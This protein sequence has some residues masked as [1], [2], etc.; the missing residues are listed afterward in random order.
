[1]PN[2]LGETIAADERLIW[3][4]IFRDIKANGR[5][6]APRNKQVLE[7]E[8]YHYELPPYVRFCSLT[9]RA[10]KLD[11]I[12][13]E[14]LWFL[15]GDP[16]D[17]SILQYSN[18]WKNIVVRGR[19]NSNYG[20][21]FFRRGGIDWVVLELCKDKDSRR[22]CITILGSED[23]H[24]RPD[25]K[26]VP[27][28]VYLNFRIRTAPGGCD[29]LNMSVHMRSQDAVYGMGND[30]PAFSILQEI[31][32]QKLRFHKYPNLQLG[33]YHHT[34]DSFH[35]YERHYAMLEELVAEDVGFD[36]IQ[37]GVGVPYI[38]S[39]DEVDYMLTDMHNG[40]EP[41][42]EYPFAK[43]LLEVRC[44]KT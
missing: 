22:A 13:Q 21:A 19:L 12:K 41:A 42:P 2:L 35:V 29:F 17:L 27:C 33:T 10:L 4:Q 28:T 7:I 1:M 37:P 18:I 25:A 26:D 36:W 34:S 38:Q 8:N 40:V 31:I 14:Q 24:L 43:W 11:Y 16:Y 20:Q 15:R 3:R 32:L 39:S 6:T 5:F 23:I 44:P 9:P 30:A